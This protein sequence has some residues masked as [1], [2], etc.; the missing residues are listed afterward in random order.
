M[1]D[2]DGVLN[3]N[4]GYVGYI[5]NFKWMP[6]AKSTI[7]YLNKKNFYVAVITNQSGIAR[8]YF[9]IKDVKKLHKF[10]KDDLK[11]INTKIDA[12]HFS[13]FHV[14]GIIKR[15]TKKSNCRKPEI[16]MFKKIQKKF[17]I[18]KKESFMIG[19]Q[20]TDMLFAKRCGVKGYFFKQGNLL[21]FIKKK[22]HD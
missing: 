13:P 10:M 17:T 4:R 9:K 14:D 12:F 7:K 19:D 21:N 2:R 16:G 11:K 15:Y 18:N 6:G 22:L 1:L 20:K 3:I 8:N 5:K